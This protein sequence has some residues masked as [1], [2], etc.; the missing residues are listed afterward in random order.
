MA[1][2]HAHWDIYGWIPGMMPSEPGQYIV[3]A[4]G[5]RGIFSCT[6]RRTHTGEIEAHVFK[7]WLRI[8]PLTIEA[9][10]EYKE[11]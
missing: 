6:A 3:K 2:T 10:K 1:I 8:D 7:Q 4:K 9:W 11:A 5:R